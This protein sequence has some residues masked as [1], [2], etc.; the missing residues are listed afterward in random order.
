MN[1]SRGFSWAKAIRAAW[2][3]VFLPL[4]IAPETGLATPIL[5]QNGTATFSQTG[6]GGGCGYCGPNEAIDGILTDSPADL[7]GWSIARPPGLSD[8]ESETAVWET[9][10]DVTA[11]EL[12]FVMLFNHFN[13]GHLLGRFRLS[14]TDDARSTFA[15]GL[16]LGGDVTADW[17]VLTNLNIDGPAGMTF[18]VLP[19]DSILVGGTIPDVGTYSVKYLNP[20]SHVTGIRL[21]AIEDP[22]LP[23]FDGPGLYSVNGNF[24]LTELTVDAGQVPG[25]PALALLALGLI[26]LN[27]F[28]RHF[29]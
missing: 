28:R 20:V 12:T 18:S 8:A 14:V 1:Y 6:L 25:P 29:G 17:T 9:A 5:L 11:D 26:A 22:A 15:D 3:I 21:E 4:T 10:E 27:Q 19:D 13:P 24:V 23:Y 2:F 16:D 7:N